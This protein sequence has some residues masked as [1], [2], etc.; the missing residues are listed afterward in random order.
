MYGKHEVE[1]YWVLDDVAPSKENKKLLD[2]IIIDMLFDSGWISEEPK[3]P[4][5]IENIDIIVREV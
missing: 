1:G 2:K 5:D 3:Q 4:L